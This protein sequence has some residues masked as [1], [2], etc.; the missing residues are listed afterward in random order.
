MELDVPTLLMMLVLT[1][2]LIALAMVTVAWGERHEG[3]QFWAAGLG[4]NALAY[5]FF[6]LRNDISPPISILLGNGLTSLALS[7]L[8]AAV[9]RPERF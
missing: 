7:Y 9:L 5:V 4:I 3:L 1:P 2:V 8:L 6:G